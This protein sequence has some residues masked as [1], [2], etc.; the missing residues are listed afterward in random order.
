MQYILARIR[1][2]V[3]KDCQDTLNGHSA[4]RRSL[5]CCHERF[6]TLTPYLKQLVP[7]KRARK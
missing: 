3:S 1:L 7:K 6:Y 5:Q 4:I 2:K